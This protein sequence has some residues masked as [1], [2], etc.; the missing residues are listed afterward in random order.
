VDLGIEDRFLLFEV[1]CKVVF[2]DCF[3][4]MEIISVDFSGQ[5][6]VDFFLLHFLVWG[7]RLRL[8]FWPWVYKYDSLILETADN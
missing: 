4:W 2:L 5:G 1:K 6:K 3:N 8:S 7:A